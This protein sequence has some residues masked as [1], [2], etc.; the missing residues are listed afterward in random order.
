[1]Q[2]INEAVVRQLKEQKGSEDV[3]LLWDKLW[4]AYQQEGNDGVDAFLNHLL[5]PSGEQG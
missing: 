2:G 5:D 3:Q 1:M 4:K